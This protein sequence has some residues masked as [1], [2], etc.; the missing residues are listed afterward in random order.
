L[1]VG[2]RP[3]DLAPIIRPN[4]RVTDSYF[5]AAVPQNINLG[6]SNLLPT[7]RICAI[8]CDRDLKVPPILVNDFEFDPVGRNLRRVID[9][10]QFVDA[11]AEDQCFDI[12]LEFPT[13]I[14]EQRKDLI[15][16]AVR[17]LQVR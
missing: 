2:I 14:G 6:I 7:L 17:F 4:G 13:V 1:T 11:D 9:H 16:L 5:G 3:E 8:S 10:P 12:V 15:L